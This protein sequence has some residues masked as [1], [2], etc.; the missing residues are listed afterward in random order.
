VAS[1]RST[2]IIEDARRSTLAFFGADLTS[3]R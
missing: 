3:T 1:L 2:E